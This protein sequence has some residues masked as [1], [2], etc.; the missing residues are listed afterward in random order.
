MSGFLALMNAGEADIA[1]LSGAID[2]CNGAAQSMADTM[3][4][5][6]EGQLTILKSQ[7]SGA[8]HFFWGNSVTGGKEDCGLGAGIY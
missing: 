5:N 2:N 8:G 7:L 3:N 1:K 6:L 4:N